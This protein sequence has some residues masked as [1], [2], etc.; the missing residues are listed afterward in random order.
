MYLCIYYCTPR[1]SRYLFPLKESL[2]HV[3]I[4]NRD[5]VEDGDIAGKF[6]AFFFHFVFQVAE[7]DVGNCSC[8]G[9]VGDESAIMGDIVTSEKGI[10]FLILGQEKEEPVGPYHIS[11]M[12][13][14]KLCE[15]THDFLGRFGVQRGRSGVICFF[16]QRRLLQCDSYLYHS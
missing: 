7:S 10:F 2:S 5:V 3:L 16:V 15:Y 8:E 11:N 9:P 1:F 12:L 14:T 6:N 13:S 4:D